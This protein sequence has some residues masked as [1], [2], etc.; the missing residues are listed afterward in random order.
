MSKPLRLC[1]RAP[2]M[3]MLE[4][5]IENG[6]S[7][8]VRPSQAGALTL[9]L[10]LVFTTLTAIPMYRQSRCLASPE[11]TGGRIHVIQAFCLYYCLRRRCSSFFFAWGGSERYD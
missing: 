10:K 7:V 1:S 6:C 2:R 3:E 8:N 9:L 4:R 5:L 11:G